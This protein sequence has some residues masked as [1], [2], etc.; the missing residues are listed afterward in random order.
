M[1]RFGLI[2]RYP[3][4]VAALIAALQSSAILYVVESRASVLR[5]GQEVLLQ[6][7]PIDTVI[8]PI[9]AKPCA[10][11]NAFIPRLNITKSVPHK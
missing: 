7:A 10:L 11:I 4:V 2:S 9:L 1:N 6:T 3:L 5:H 8:I